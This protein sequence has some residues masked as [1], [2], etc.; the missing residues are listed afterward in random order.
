MEAF[1]DNEL[2]MKDSFVHVVL[3]PNHGSLDKELEPAQ[4][5]HLTKRSANV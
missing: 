3:Y 5:S 2:T 1:L 4:N